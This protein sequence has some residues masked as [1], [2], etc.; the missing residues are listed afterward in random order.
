MYSLWGFSWKQRAHAFFSGVHPQMFEVTLIQVV[1]KMLSA[2]YIFSSNLN[3][4]RVS[5]PVEVLRALK[6]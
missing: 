2:T 6:V 4:W 5:H 1:E 3:I